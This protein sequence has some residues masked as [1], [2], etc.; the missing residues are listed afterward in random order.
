MCI[1][2]SPAP[3]AGAMELCRGICSAYASKLFEEQ[4]SESGDYKILPSTGDRA[5]GP[6]GSTSWRVVRNGHVTGQYRTVM[7]VTQGDQS[8]LYSCDCLVPISQ[9][10]PC[11]H[12]IRVLLEKGL[13]SFQAHLFH[14]RWIVKELLLHPEYA[15][16]ELPHEIIRNLRT[17]NFM[18]VYGLATDDLSDDTSVMHEDDG[19]ADFEEQANVEGFGADR[20]DDARDEPVLPTKAGPL[21]QRDRAPVRANVVARYN[22]IKGMLND[23]ASVACAKQ[24]TFMALHALVTE[25]ILI[26]RGA[27]EPRGLDPFLRQV[28]SCLTPDAP[29]PAPVPAPA[30]TA[31]KVLLPLTA[32]VEGATANP[33][34]EAL[35]LS[36]ADPI[37]PGTQVGDLGDGDGDGDIDNPASGLP[38]A[39]GKRARAGGRWT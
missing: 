29:A 16:G 1:G 19:I 17:D 10:I 26:S 37:I 32:T 7:E 13:P 14:T 9:G 23:L 12:I 15:P 31:D 22:A 38:P 20:D 35:P 18:S 11:R 5:E 34:A 39:A 28:V 6:A 33:L 27:R 2:P 8:T 21:S 4:L 3:A 24:P 30:V 36:L 25:L